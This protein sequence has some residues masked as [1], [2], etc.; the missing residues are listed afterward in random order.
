MN[1]II[2]TERVLLR[3]FCLEDIERF[4][5]ICA[6]PK[7]M[8]YIGDGN[9]VSRE[10]IAEKIPEWI[11]LYEKQ[12]YGLM[13]LIMKATNKLIGFCGFIHQIVDEIEYVELGYRL[14]EAYWEQGI[15]TE[16]AV[17]VRNY[18]FNVLDIPMLIAIIHHKNDASKRVA[19]K[20]GMKLM[21]QT[22]FKN[23]LVDVF[24]LK[25]ED[26]VLSGQTN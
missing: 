19:K 15:A 26:L 7:V 23:A 17:A 9:P 8:R 6:N 16:A 21:K 18:A 22:N 20:I 2:E 5:E 13:A 1:Q 12:T 3:P 14:D 25:R 24:C 11:A 10:V 4:A